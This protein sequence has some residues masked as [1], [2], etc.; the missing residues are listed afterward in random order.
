VAG[1]AALAITLRADAGKSP[2]P[3]SC[4]RGFPR[5]A[6]NHTRGACAPRAASAFGI[7]ANTGRRAG[8]TPEGGGS[9]RRDI[10]ALWVCMDRVFGFSITGDLGHQLSKVLFYEKKF[11]PGE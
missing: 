6:E 4:V 9:P 3:F 1:H 11:N 10:L 5:G 8:A 2:G 7:K